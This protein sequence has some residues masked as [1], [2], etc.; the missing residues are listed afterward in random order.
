MRDVLTVTIN[1]ALD[2]STSAAHV[3]PTHK[4]R[5]DTLQRHPGGGGVNVARVI[6]RLGGDCTAL[7]PAGGA[8]GAVFQ[9]LLNDEG[10]P[11][12][13]VPIAGETRE[14]FSVKDTSSNNEF[15]F[16]LPGPVL[17][18][19]EWQACLDRISDMDT[20]PKFVVASGSLP[21]GVPEDFYVRLNRLLKMRNVGLVLDTSGAA[22]SLTLDEGVFLCKP[23]LRE[24]S[25]LCG[26]VLSTEADWRHAGQDLIKQGRAQVLVLTLGEGGACLFIDG[27]SYF[28]PALAV[29]V[30]SA[31]GAGD[32]F[33]GAMMWALSKGH[34]LPDAFKYGVAGA[35]AALLST[36]TGL[37]QPE[38]VSRLY[39]SVSLVR[40]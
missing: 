20:L 38:D 1:P 4:V 14:S 32:S 13:C 18:M 3:V 16:V 29:N 17:Q 40:L 23:S 8:S 15:R 22:L 37:C 28:A 2:L 21:P 27:A 10:V 11:S 6:H 33:V 26:Q 24:L 39:P 30:L 36:G 31:I 5:C 35:T 9:Q 7:Y 34:D 25:E 19:S 12:I